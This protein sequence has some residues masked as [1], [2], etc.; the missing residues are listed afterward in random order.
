MRCPHCDNHVLQKSGDKIRLRTQGQ[1][2]FDEGGKCR[3]RCFWCKSAI[4]IPLEIQEGVPIS[5]ERF[6]LPTKS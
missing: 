4:E 6:F 1:I 5:A 2:I 3:T